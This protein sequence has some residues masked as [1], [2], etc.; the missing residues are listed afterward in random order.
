MHPNHNSPQW[1]TAIGKC[2]NYHKTS[3]R[4]EYWTWDTEERIN[5]LSELTWSSKSKSYHILS[6]TVCQVGEEPGFW[7]ILC[8][9]STTPSP[10]RKKKL[11][12]QNSD[13]NKLQI[14]KTWQILETSKI[15]KN[16]I[17]LLV[18][19]WF[20]SVMLFFYKVIRYFCLL[21]DNYFVTFSIEKRERLFPIFP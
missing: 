8:N 12:E 6:T 2:Q 5:G 15:Q 17:F 20:T 11:E 3:V 4:R 18:D 19:L 9:F 16:I 14:F 7:G 13:K 21:Q 10:I 1:E